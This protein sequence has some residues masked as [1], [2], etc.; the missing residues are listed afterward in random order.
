MPLFSSSSSSSSGRSMNSLSL[1]GTLRHRCFTPHTAVVAGILSF[2][3]LAVA[4]GGSDKT[5]DKAA[6]SNSKE[7]SAVS[8]CAAAD[9]TPV[10]LA[11]LQFITE[12][13][14]RAMRFLT[15]AGTDSAVPD[16]GFKILQD[17]GPTYF[18]SSDAKGQAQVRQKLDLAG[19]WPSLLVVYHGTST[20]S[21][22]DTVKVTLGGHYVGGEHDA[23]II[24]NRV[25]S[26]F[27][28]GTQWKVVKA[29]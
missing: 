27:C 22:G 7:A 26:V 4:C 29:P 15:A 8:A 11:V 23:K 12:A 14:P 6:E 2:S 25:V 21:G 10:A 16:D 19:P 20:N 5:S 18:Y 28:E 1:R 9:S 17:K 3:L 13:S 24:E